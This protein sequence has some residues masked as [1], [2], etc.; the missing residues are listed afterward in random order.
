[1]GDAIR[2]AS[3]DRAVVTQQCLY[4]YHFVT[5]AAELN[6]LGKRDL[7]VLAKHYRSHAGVLKL[8]RGDATEKVYAARTAVVIEKLSAMGVA[9]E[10]VTVTDGVPGGDGMTT[11]RLIKAMQ[12]AES[13][14]T[15]AQQLDGSMI[16]GQKK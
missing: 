6:D 12:A 10:Q 15:T 7:Q 8:S 1:M 9:A 16:G 4:P 11:E 14:S 5:D 2:R 3:L 13:E